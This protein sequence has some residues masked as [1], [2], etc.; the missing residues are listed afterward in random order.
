MHPIVLTVL[1][2]ARGAW[3]FRFWMLGAA[4]VVCALGWAFVMT[5]P[6]TYQASARVYLDTQGALRP[7]L[8]GIAVEP[9][10]Q[11]DLNVVRQAM[12]STPALEKVART[13][14]LDDG[15][16]TPQDYE[17]LIDALR[18]RIV[19]TRDAAGT[20]ADGTYQIT[21]QDGDRHKSL[22][23]VKSL[24]DQF[25]EGTL[26]SKRTG[27]EGAQR[28]LESQIA[29]YEGRLQEAENRLAD[30]K[31]NNI[32]K[33][34]GDRGDYFARLQTEMNGLTDVRS[35]LSLAEARRAELQRQLAGEEPVI[36]G[37]DADAGR[38]DRGGGGDVSARIQELERRREEL[39]LRF[40]EKHPEVQNVD[41]T[42]ADL[43]ARQ[44]AELERVQRG[45]RATGDLSSSLKTNPVYQSL[46]V[47]SKRA[48]V[49]VAEIRQ[50]LAQRE[51]RV[52]ELRRMVNSVP[53]VE[54]ELARLNRDYTVTR[55]Q[56]ES[57]VQRLETAKLSDQA[58]KTGTVNFRVIDP[59]SVPLKPIAPN[60][61]LLMTGI[62][63]VG[64][65]LALALG[66]G[67]NLANPVFFTTESLASSL[68]ARVIGHVSRVAADATL[69]VSRRQTLL[70]VGGVAGL[71]VAFAIALLM[72]Q[73]FAHFAS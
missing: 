4:W 63:T 55:A 39:L 36:F 18:K 57:L 32:G 73:V 30:F 10:V 68:G 54:A 28:F 43:Q 8:R 14:G 47:E 72:P 37:L 51:A 66:L 19:I 69:A 65:G 53:E 24:L 56:Y 15:A 62:L 6:N 33:M 52:A 61:P 3:R 46:Q 29:E 12:L 50:D 17:V 67:L 48:E 41:R 25:V 70:F 26:G 44:A 22:L 1:D 23:L 27:Q 31:K 60:R 64:L 21:F 11:S 58:D 9:D 13:T 2:E 71:L 49:Q 20:A 59:P 16:A 7:L 34:P 5:M 35:A 42:L 38:N 40:T 45:R